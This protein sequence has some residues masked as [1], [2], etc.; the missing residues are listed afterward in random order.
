VEVTLKRRKRSGGYA[1][2]LLLG[3]RGLLAWVEL[4]VL[5]MVRFEA[6]SLSEGA[7]GTLLPALLISHL[8]PSFS[9]QKSHYDS[10]ACGQLAAWPLES[11]LAINS[12][13]PIAHDTTSSD[14]SI[15][16]LASPPFIQ[17]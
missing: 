3:R 1:D 4:I 11:A 9:R 8:D 2:H 17:S 6:T 15:Y 12:T 7:G 14:F 5:M 13:S 16:P 10:M